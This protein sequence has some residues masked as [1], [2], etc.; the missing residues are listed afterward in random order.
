MF[1]GGERAYCMVVRPFL[2]DIEWTAEN[3]GTGR[4]DPRWT[5]RIGVNIPSTLCHLSRV[6]VTSS[7]PSMSKFPRETDDKALLCVKLQ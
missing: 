2:T 3:P 5:E 7:V 1:L 4:K 6:V